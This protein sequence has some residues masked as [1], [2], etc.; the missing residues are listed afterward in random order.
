MFLLF[1]ALISIILTL[2]GKA[3]GFTFLTS[4]YALAVLVPSLAVTARRLHDT[5]RS[6]WWLLLGLIPFIGDFVLTIFAVLD[7]QTGP[8]AYGSN[9]KGDAYVS[10]KTN[11]WLIVI[12]CIGALAI[13]MAGISAWGFLS[14]MRNSQTPTSQNSSI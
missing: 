9:P 7:S 12:L 6:A 5:G 4:I 8:N 3:I 11:V 13:L 14:I 2:I 10:E 1:S